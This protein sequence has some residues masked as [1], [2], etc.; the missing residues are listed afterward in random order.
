MY[1]A[2]AN[3][4]R[5]CHPG[6]CAQLSGALTKGLK[7]V[8]NWLTNGMAARARVFAKKLTKEQQLQSLS[9]HNV[10]VQLENLLTYPVVATELKAGKL[11]MA[12]WVYDIEHVLECDPVSDESLRPQPR[13]SCRC[14]LRH[15]RAANTRRVN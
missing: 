5:K 14:G 11:K 12:I 15:N 7:S 9:E 1:L 13:C 8:A 6:S 10:V 3:S 2:D 4:S